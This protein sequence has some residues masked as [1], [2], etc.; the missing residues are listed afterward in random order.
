MTSIIYSY[1]SQNPRHDAALG[2]P[3]PMSNVTQQV[4]GDIFG[5]DGFTFGDLLDI[6]N[7]L[8]QLPI[9]GSIYRAVTGDT[10]SAASRMAGGALLGG[11]L[12]FVMSAVNAGLDAATGADAGGH[13]LAALTGDNAA[14]R[15]YASAAYNKAFWLAS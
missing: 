5:E 2:K 12:G 4:A 7:P 6:V 10:I 13:V 8:Q 15:Q 11:P 3:A 14:G 1:P 9:V